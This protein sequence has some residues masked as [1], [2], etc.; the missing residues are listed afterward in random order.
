MGPRSLPA[1][2][3]TNL[4]HMRA[5]LLPGLASCILFVFRL[6]RASAAISLPNDTLLTKTISAPRITHLKVIGNIDLTLIKGDHSKMEI[7]GRKNLVESLI[8]E[9]DSE[10][11]LISENPHTPTETARIKIVLW[12]QN[13]DIPMMSCKGDVR[14]A[15]Q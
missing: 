3:H 15:Y 4:I 1:V 12:L 7:S 14:I 8:F 2:Y 11:M 10:S 5:I 6:P 9:T 13:P